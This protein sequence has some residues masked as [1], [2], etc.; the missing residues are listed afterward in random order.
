M[1]SRP[2]WK[3]LVLTTLGLSV[4]LLG[5][6][7]LAIS[8]AV[9][10]HHGLSALDWH[11][12]RLAAHAL[13][14]GSTLFAF[15]LLLA[16][17]AAKIG[18]APVHNWLPDAHSE[19]PPPISALLSAALLPSVLLVAWRVKQILQPVGREPGRHAPCSSAFGLASLLV[20]VPFLWQSMPW[21]RLLAYSSMEHM[22]VI[23]LGI[24]FGTPLAIA[25]VVIH[26]AGHALAKALG[27]YAAL[28]LLRVDPGAAKR[29]PLGVAGSSPSTATAMGVSLAALAGMPPS[30]L[31]LSELLIVLGGVAAGQLVVSAIAVIALAL[32]FLGLLHALVEGVVG[33]RGGGARPPSAA[34][35]AHDRGADR[36]IRRRTAGAARC[37]A[38][39]G[40]LELHRDTRQR[41]AVTSRAD[42]AVGLAGDDRARPRGRRA[43]RRRLG[44]QSA[45]QASAGG[46]CSS[47]PSGMR[48]LAA[49][50]PDGAIDTIADLTPAAN[51]DER[52]AHDLYGL[53]F[54]GHEPMRALAR[55]TD[56]PE[57]WMTPVHG[58]DVHQVAVGPIHAGVIESGHFRF[59][60]VGERILAMD[61]RLFYK[62]RGLERASEGLSPEQALPYV[63]RACA[64]CAVANTVAYAQA[65][66]DALGLRPTDDLRVARTVL[67]EL[68]RVYNHLHDIG[69]ICAGVGF[70]P[71]S[72]AFAA[73][74]DRAQQTLAAALRAPL[75]V[76]H[77]RHRERA[78]PHST[79]AAADTA[80]ASL[81]ELHT[82]FTAAW[83]DL[84]F[85][86]S[87]QARL[88]GVGVLDAE[89][90]VRLGA[91]GPAARAA[92]L[93]RGRPQPQPATRLR[94][95]RAGGD[96][97][98]RGGRRRAAAAAR[99]RTRRLVRHARRAARAAARAR[100]GAGRRSAADS[101]DGGAGRFGAGRVESARGATTC[102]V[103]LTDGVIARVH[104]RTGSYA[105]WPAL[106]H[107]TAGNL[108]PDFPLINK[109]FEL[110]YACVDR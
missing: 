7:V 10:G 51:W 76:R 35:S 59:H 93:A 72:M 26:V 29:A 102:I 25:G 13:P 21:K 32:G 80:R 90:A 103:E 61:P 56:D 79:R 58:D 41:C 1:R 107:A 83:R 53:R 64:A 46:R 57:Q 63:Q 19:A 49:D 27:F 43:V 15:V 50:T 45:G 75:P 73:L 44:D 84:E 106:A 66:E 74:K 5:I 69:A 20:A 33:D 94:R 28:P 105:N 42:R 87:L 78:P 67:L 81:R 38:A 16:G 11:A 82:E 88:G 101:G 65:V 34:R 18:W 52:E 77:D 22:G 108:L 98:A 55:H 6:V 70:A 104:L 14:K 68:E 54:A 86:G 3:Y 100:G 39:A 62:H 36:G 37:R 71:G 92:G 8:Q 4:A 85:T 89:D 91:V 95:L 97:T 23:A 48:A 2:G 17:L 31:F 110:C 24:G 99:G 96:A 40:R 60:V 9:V 30:P 109:S 47:A 12:L